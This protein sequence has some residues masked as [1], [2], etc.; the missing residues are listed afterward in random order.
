MDNSQLYSAISAI[1]TWAAVGCALVAVWLQNR[2][3][4]RLMCLQ[5]FIQLAA[6][7]ESDSMQRT[8]ARIASKLLSNPSATEIDDS[9][10][11]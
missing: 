4:K 5:L 6:Q 1:G 8:R 10:L 2:S 9:L 11:V 3:A 7:Y